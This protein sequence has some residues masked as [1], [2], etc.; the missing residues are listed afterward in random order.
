M[1]EL[2]SPELTAHLAVAARELREQSPPATLLPAIHRVLARRRKAPGS[3]PSRAWMGWAGM[4]TAGTALA[5][6]LAM[7]PAGQVV[8][9][10]EGF[11]TLAGE[12]AWRAAAQTD[13]GHVW[14]VPAEIT[15]A[16]LAAFGLPYDPANA[17]ERI[18][19]Q[20][21]MHSSGDVLAVRVHH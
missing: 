17:A 12:D 21:L 19:A 2:V 10:S 7:R 9:D 5:I 1:N 3:R 18:S 16:R 13:S 4:A 6:V 14:L 20:L 8:A 15:Q 11:L